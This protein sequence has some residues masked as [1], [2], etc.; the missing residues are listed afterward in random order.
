[1]VR[2]ESWQKSRMD[3]ELDG[4]ASEIAMDGRASK[5]VSTDTEK[6]HMTAATEL[7]MR[8]GQLMAK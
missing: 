3:V 8:A 2:D 1:M 4:R 6:Q 7:T 5:I